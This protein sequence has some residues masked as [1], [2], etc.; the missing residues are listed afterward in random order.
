MQP[1][2][3]SDSSPDHSSQ[4]PP[5]SLHESVDFTGTTINTRE[6]HLAWMCRPRFDALDYNNKY[7]GYLKHVDS[8]GDEH[9]HYAGP[10]VLSATDPENSTPPSEGEVSTPDSAPGPSGAG[11]AVGTNDGFEVSHMERRVGNVRRLNIDDEDLEEPGEKPKEEDL[12][13][14]DR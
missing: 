8:S 5:G 10:H 7:I 1:T 14:S 3:P 2:P 13:G 6:D 11:D 12:E 9:W 4:N